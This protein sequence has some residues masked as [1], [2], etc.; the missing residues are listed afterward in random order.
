MRKPEAGAYALM[1]LL[2]A[3][4]CAVTPTPAKTPGVMQGVASDP[5]AKGP[6]V[7]GYLGPAATPDAF[8]II[9]IAPREGEPRNDADWAVFRKTRSLEGSARWKLAQND[10]SYVPAALLKDFSCA[11]GAE[12]TPRTAPTL[13]TIM[14]RT[15]S[16]AGAA[17][18][19]AKKKYQRTRP[20]L[21]NPGAICIARD[22]GLEASFDYPSGHASASWAEGL[23]LAELAPDRSSQILQRARAYGESR[24][25]C[26]VHNWSAVEAGRVNGA[27]VFAALHGSAEFLADM[28]RA[29]LEVE[30]ARKSGPRP[31][32]AACE[33]EAELTR[34]LTVN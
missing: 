6:E 11:V 28:S 1:A 8:A 2:L 14:A 23:A 17:A 10:D 16:D 29:R 7:K 9:P 12:L 15:G 26:G 24:I 5:A 3:A 31:D 32:A 25:V 20:F 27:S 33:A 4:A 22:A 13:A 34:P 18:A 21:H 19:S 30:A